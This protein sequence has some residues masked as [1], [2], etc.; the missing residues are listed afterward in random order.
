MLVALR[1]GRGCQLSK[2]EV[3]RNTMLVA[4]RG[5]GGG[6]QLSKQEVLHNTMLVALRGGRGVSIIL[7]RSIA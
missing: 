7:T 4:L 3:L 1:G 2:Q 6:C 5:G